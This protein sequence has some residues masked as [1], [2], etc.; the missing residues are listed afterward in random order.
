MKFTKEELKEYIESEWENMSQEEKYV[1]LRDCNPTFTEFV[2]SHL[3]DGEVVDID[4]ENKKFYLTQ[5]LTNQG[6][7][8][9]PFKKFKELSVTKT[10]GEPVVFLR[11][12]EIE[13]VHGD[14]SI[15]GTGNIFI[16]WSYI[17]DKSDIAVYDKDYQL[18]DFRFEHFDLNSKHAIISISD[19]YWIRDGSVQAII[20]YGN[21]EKKE[22]I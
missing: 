10:E 19:R 1:R 11:N 13:L 9:I 4:F 8:M 5:K 21:I 20:A 7:K 2:F 22:N 16:D 12:A 15:E 18:I 6:L 3:S 14:D 17:S